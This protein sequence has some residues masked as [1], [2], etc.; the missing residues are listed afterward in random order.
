MGFHEG[1]LK[2]ETISIIVMKKK[3]IMRR[4]IETI[5]FQILIKYMIIMQPLIINNLKN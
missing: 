3:L 4:P 2:T 5:M 1:Q